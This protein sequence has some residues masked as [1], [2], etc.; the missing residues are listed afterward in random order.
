MLGRIATSR[1]RRACCY[2]ALEAAPVLVLGW[3]LLCC[4]PH[5]WVC[6]VRWQL[7]WP[8]DCHGRLDSTDDPTFIMEL[9]CCYASYR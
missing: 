6:G 2:E 8:T 1:R 9:V 3:G 5:G 7:L 4:T